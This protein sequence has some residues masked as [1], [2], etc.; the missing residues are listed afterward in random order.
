MKRIV[1]AITLLVTVLSMSAATGIKQ[2]TVNHISQDQYRQLVQDYTTLNEGFVTL[3]DHPVIV[4]FWAPWCGPCRKLSPILEELARVYSGKI[5]FYSINVDENEEL[6]AAYGI[7][8]IPLLL[9]IP[10]GDTPSAAQGYRP[11]E[12]LQDAIRQV[13]GF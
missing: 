8:S 7:S 3:N 1:L 4:D 9:F 2:G 12:V 13:F 11:K 5:T 6:A 10:V